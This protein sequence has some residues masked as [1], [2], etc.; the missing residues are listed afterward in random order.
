MT[1]R[2]KKKKK[3]KKKKIINE[4]LYHELYNKISLNQFD[5][6]QPLHQTKEIII[7]AKLTIENDAG[8]KTKASKDAGK[9]VKDAGKE[10]DQQQTYQI[11]FI[12]PPAN[13]FSA[14]NS[15]GL[16]KIYVEISFDQGQTFLEAEKKKKKKK[17]KMEKIFFFIPK[18]FH[19]Q[20]NSSEISKKKK[21]KKKKSKK[22]K[23]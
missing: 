21:K 23:F 1:R 6:I 20:N 2:R 11:K 3:K 10:K 9:K 19:F 13:E 15:K 14:Y 16:C 5:P 12:S 4:N 18:C 17:K 7:P 8:N 22:N